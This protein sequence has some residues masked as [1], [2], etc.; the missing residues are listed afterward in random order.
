MN[1][2]SISNICI[3]RSD[4]ND[5]TLTFLHMGWY[6]HKHTCACAHT[7]THT[8]TLPHTHNE[9]FRDGL[10]TL[11]TY[12]S[13]F[14]YNNLEAK[15]ESNEIILCPV[16]KIISVSGMNH[17][18]SFDNTKLYSGSRGYTAHKSRKATLGQEVHLVIMFLFPSGIPPSVFQLLWILLLPGNIKMKAILGRVYFLTFPYN[19]SLSKDVRAETQRAV[20]WRLELIRGYG[21]GR[22]HVYWLAHL[23][24]S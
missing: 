22:A 20:V 3:E 15:M 2:D 1:K 19:W 11:Q 9:S 14:R 17:L 16:L 10:K 4:T 23:A 12:F 21:A 18:M 24:F 8:C 5:S 6:A 7:H 13:F